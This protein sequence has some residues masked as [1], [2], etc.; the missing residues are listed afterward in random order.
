MYVARRFPSDGGVEGSFAERLLRLGTQFD[1][2]MRQSVEESA[3]RADREVQLA[4]EEADWLH[5]QLEGERQQSA[6]RLGL[7]AELQR[8]LEEVQSAHRQ[9]VEEREHWQTECAVLEERNS[10]LEAKMAAVA[11]SEAEASA[12]AGAVA[13]LAATPPSRAAIECCLSALAEDASGGDTATDAMERAQQQSRAF[14]VEAMHEMLVIAAS[15]D[16]LTGDAPIPARCR[17]SSAAAATCGREVTSDAIVRRVVQLWVARLVSGN[18]GLALR[19]AA[20]SGSAETMAA[21][22]ALGGP[23]V[24][25]QAVGGEEAMIPAAGTAPA[26]DEADPRSCLVSMCVE[27][28]SSNM[29][30]MVLDH[31]RGA[32]APAALEAVRRARKLALRCSRKDLAEALAAHLIMELSMAGNMRYRSGD[33][34][35]AVANYEEAISLCEDRGNRAGATGREPHRGRMA[36]GAVGDGGRHAVVGAGGVGDG[37]QRQNI[38]R[39]RYN[40]ARAL[41]R[42]ERWAEAR[43]EASAVVDLDKTYA[44]AYALR[45]QASMA[46]FD[47]EAAQADWER[48]LAL[49]ASGACHIGDE[50]IADDVLSLWQRRR[51]ECHRQAALGHYEVLELPRLSSLASIRRAYRDLVRKWHPDKNQH[52]PRDHRD[53]CARQFNRLREAF[54]AIGDEASKRAYDTALLLREARPFS[55][56]EGMTQKRGS[57][58]AS[59]D[60][61]LPSESATAATASCN[62]RVFPNASIPSSAPASAVAPPGK[63]VVARVI[64]ADVL[65]ADFFDQGPEADSAQHLQQRERESAVAAELLADASAPEARP[66]R[67]SL[68]C[69]GSSA[70][71]PAAAAAAA[72]A[73]FEELMAGELAGAWPGRWRHPREQQEEEQRPPSPGHVQTEFGADSAMIGELH[74]GLDGATEAGADYLHSDDGDIPA[75][76]L[77]GARRRHEAI[78]GSRG[79]H[80]EGE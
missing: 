56:G 31:L 73:E 1:R 39:L 41:H 61:L 16:F 50:V 66:H 30:S 44:N 46:A 69:P 8:Q 33:Y 48:L 5:R 25:R 75:G 78:I 26:E 58:G 3:Q 22:L 71:A 42:L 62:G 18:R 15:G 67:S 45:A 65:E 29:L 70:P 6:A 38:V 60:D 80:D 63:R 10:L 23:A 76:R 37:V 40:L 43:E 28:G 59:Q 12:S 34:E 54:E 27:H 11:L 36:P 53:R 52:L 55:P 14:P 79:T 51:D 24:A 19:A 2:E 68:G 17:S 77:G 21:L 74:S 35:I 72:M 20:R 32:R 47:W 57:R 4:R 13:P 9:E 7:C 49:A 64:G